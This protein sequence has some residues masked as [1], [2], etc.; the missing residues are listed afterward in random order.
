MDIVSNRSEMIELMN[1]EGK[2][3]LQAMLQLSE[4]R[5]LMRGAIEDVQD[6][7]LEEIV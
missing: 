4:L 2:T 7:E 1:S 6:S 3:V 5:M